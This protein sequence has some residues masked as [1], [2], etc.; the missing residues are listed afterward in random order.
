MY[1]QRILN[2]ANLFSAWPELTHWKRRQFIMLQ[3]SSYYFS[4]KSW[5]ERVSGT[6]FKFSAIRAKFYSFHHSMVYA[7]SNYDNSLLVCYHHRRWLAWLIYWSSEKTLPDRSWL[8]FKYF[9]YTKQQKACKT[10]IHPNLFA[11]RY[12]HKG[13]KAVIIVHSTLKSLHIT[14][15]EY[16]ELLYF[17]HFAHK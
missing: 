16:Q 9:S 17:N 14:S 12:E 3:P 13:Q 6:V 4:R 15:S 8:S 2:G 11:T 5:C 1:K 10:S 7:V